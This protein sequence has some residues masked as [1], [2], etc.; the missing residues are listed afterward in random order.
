MRKLAKT[1]TLL[2]LMLLWVGSGVHAQVSIGIRIGPPPAPR[3]VRVQP[4]RPAPNF[5]WI[6]GYWYPVGSHYRWHN[7]YWTRPPYEGARWVGPR[8]DGERFYAGYWD[9]ER[10]RLEHDH[11]WDRNKDR[12]FNRRDRR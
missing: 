7:G 4:P 8:H 9:G 6:E 10:G 5:V 3:V 11:R 1:P 12:D 2:V